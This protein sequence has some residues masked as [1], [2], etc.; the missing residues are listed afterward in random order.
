MGHNNINMKT[1]RKG[2]SRN[3]LNILT[4]LSV[5]YN[6]DTE[7]ES[8]EYCCK[9][10]IT[11]KNDLPNLTPESPKYIT[12]HFKMYKILCRYS[13]K[14]SLSA[15]TEFG[16]KCL[17]SKMEDTNILIQNIDKFILNFN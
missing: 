8:I 7:D 6:N 5:E 10:S 11:L 3:L 4:K 1:I 2:D 17:I 14:Y 15:T 13:Y 9:S 16:D 12:F